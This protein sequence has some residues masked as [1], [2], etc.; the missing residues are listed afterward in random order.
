MDTWVAQSEGR[1]KAGRSVLTTDGDRPPAYVQIV[2][3]S[4]FEEAMQVGVL[5]NRLLTRAPAVVLATRYLNP[6]GHGVVFA[7][8][9]RWRPVQTQRKVPA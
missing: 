7:H 3:F 1:R 8:E 2:E 6:R 5:G 9:V 4:S